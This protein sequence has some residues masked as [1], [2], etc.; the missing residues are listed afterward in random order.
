MTI[1][2]GDPLVTSCLETNFLRVKWAECDHAGKYPSAIKQPHASVHSANPHFLDPRVK[3]FNITSA[4][5]CQCRE[6]L[7]QPIPGTWTTLLLFVAFI[8]SHEL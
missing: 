8:S 6:L 5:M 2:H 3:R 1:V 4:L 7:M